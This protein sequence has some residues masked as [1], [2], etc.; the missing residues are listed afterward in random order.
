MNTLPSR[1]DITIAAISILLTLLLNN[2]IMTAGTKIYATSDG[3]IS[4]PTPTEEPLSQE[5][6]AAPARTSVE[7]R[8]ASVSVG[9]YTSIALTS[10]NLPV[11]SYYDSTN[12]DLKLAVCNDA[13]C[14]SPAI[15]TIDSTG[16]VGSYTSIALTSSNLPVISYVDDSNGV[17]KLAVCTNAA[18]TSPAISTIDST[19]DVGY[20]T[21][22]ALTSSN[23]PVISYYYRTN[24]DLKLAV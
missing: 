3:R 12:G 21:S 18:C 13:T 19:G 15:S 10:S 14:T 4:T 17:L 20:T 23:V 22:L 24:E 11:I 6:P 1:K 2:L 8:S 9:M 7:P 5:L 16:N